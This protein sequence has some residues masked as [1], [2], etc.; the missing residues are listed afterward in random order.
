MRDSKT[1]KIQLDTGKDGEVIEKEFTVKELSIKSIIALS[2]S[3]A[4]FSDSKEEEPKQTSTSTS[5]FIPTPDIKKDENGKKAEELNTN[6][7]LYKEFTDMGIDISQIMEETCDFKME[8]LIDLYPSDVRE[9]YAA[10]Q[11]V[12]QTFLDVLRKLKILEMFQT[13]MERAFNNFSKML[14]I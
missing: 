14:V 12:N 8:D 5:K 9:L 3:N 4:F 10:F 11:E 1:V 6:K 2:Q 7:S 13:V